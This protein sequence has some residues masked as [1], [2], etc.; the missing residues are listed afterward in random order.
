MDAD[1]L[2]GGAISAAQTEGAWNEDNKGD[3]VIDHITAGTKKS[4]RQFYR[5][6]KED[7]YYPSHNAI[8]FYHHYK[9]DIA[10]FSEM[11]F[12][13]LRTSIAWTRIFPKGDEEKPNP[14]GIKFYHNLFDEC[15][16]Y[17]I[18]PLIT[19]SHYDMPYH[20]CVVYNGWQNRK[21]I[22]FFLH[23][24]KT[25][26]TE[27][28]D[29]VN[30]WITFN[31]MNTLVSRFGN[32]LSGGI[33]PGDGEDMFGIRHMGEKET[34]E[35]ISC[36]FT[37]LHNQFVASACAVKL[38]HEINPKNMVGCMVSAAPVY[39]YTC[40]PDDAINAD[41]QMK[42]SN[43]FTG[44]VCVKGEYPYYMNRFFTENDIHIKKEP[45]DSDILKEGTV[46]FFTFSYYSSRVAS[47]DETVKKT[48]G[49]M[50][51]GVKNPYLHES[52]WGWTID[53]KGLR[54]LLNMVYDRYGI[55][56][57]IVENGLGAEDKIDSDGKIHDEYRT[58]YLRAH[59]EQMKEAVKDGVKLIGYTP[60]GCIDLVSLSTGEMKKR[61]GFIYT[62]IDDEGKGSGKRIK[63]DSFYWYKKCI[64]SNGEEL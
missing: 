20:I 28:R 35:E 4:P 29:D 49:N 55:P 10:L 57:M 51:T 21:T 64:I 56:I 32:L 46:D 53:P 18:K 26:F 24:C 43:W 38:A 6:I 13:V 5:E 59:I 33:L 2:W 58:E 7:R 3:S 63:K 16:K 60:W 8:D 62:D 36:R 52:E 9:E 40:A 25:V 37:A 48:S 41:F 44:D 54:L 45:S 34:G 61:Y 1:F 47:C 22:D 11:G 50:M 23:F 19:L 15:K 39:P 30:M 14:E 12:K 31:E 27:Y 42:K 17:G